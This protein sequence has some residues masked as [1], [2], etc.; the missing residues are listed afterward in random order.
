M[1]AVLSDHEPF[2]QRFDI[3]PFKPVYLMTRDD[4]A[5]L[6]AEMHNVDLFIAQLISPNY[7]PP[8]TSGLRSRMQETGKAL[9]FQIAWFNAYNPEMTYLK[10]NGRNFQG[11]FGDYHSQIVFDAFCSGL[12]VDQAVHAMTG[13]WDPIGDCAKLGK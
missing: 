2:T 8:G 7:L 11:A 9:F 4:A 13:D 1:A 6:E 10:I 12:T 3:V 5:S